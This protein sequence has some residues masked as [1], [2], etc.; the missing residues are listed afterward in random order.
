MQE[1]AARVD[2]EAVRPGP[3]VVVR[4]QAGAD[5]AVQADSVPAARSAAQRAVLPEAPAWDPVEL[6]A[7]VVPA[8]VAS[9]RARAAPVVRAWVPVALAWVLVAPGWAR[10]APGSV[11]VAVGEDREGAVAVPAWVRAVRAEAIRAMD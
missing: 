2:S 6:A 10:A 5:S 9:A 4:L 11:V 7:R 1:L 3:P 8:E